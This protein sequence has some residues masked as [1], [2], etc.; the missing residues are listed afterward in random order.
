M[1]VSTGSFHAGEREVQRRAGLADEAQAV[2]RIVGDA[3]SPAAARFLE[4]QRLAIAASLDASGQ[5]W[6]SVL[7]GPA[8]FLRTVDPRRLR[9]A[10]VPADDDPLAANLRVRPEIGLL[11]IDP[12][13]RRR[14]RVN[15]RGTLD[16]DG[17]VVRTDEV[18]GN[19]PKYIQRRRLLGEASS[20]RGSAVT[21]GRLSAAQRAWIASADT[22]FIASFHPDS[23]ADA[24]HRGGEPGFVRVEDDRR[25]VMPDYPGNAMFNTLGNLLEHPRAGLLFLDFATGDTLQVA[26]RAA[27]RFEPERALAVEVDEVR[28][29]PGGHRLAWEL[30]ERSPSNPRA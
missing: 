27:L 28:E 12:Q 18:Y 23:G 19:C 21:S 14:M 10:A 9:I 8:G 2:G 7:S 1:G 4:T 11:V 30:I 5:P 3:I 20:P 29:T 26:G 6:A 15:G 25:I 24:S 13:T 16:R 17:V 22:L